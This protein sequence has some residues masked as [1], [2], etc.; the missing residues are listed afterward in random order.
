[1][2][3]IVGIIC[4]LFG[5]VQTTLGLAFIFIILPTLNPVY[6]Q[7]EA[8]STQNFYIAPILLVILGII[9]IYFFLAN[10]GYV[11]KQNPQFV[12]KWNLTVLIISF[13]GTSVLIGI[14]TYSA[15]APIYNISENL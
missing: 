13:I 15:L 4:C 12:Q 2:N 14:T 8:V 5:F 1:M 10:F 11:L 3:K 7:F 6:V 9:N